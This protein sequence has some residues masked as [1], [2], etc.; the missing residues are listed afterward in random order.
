MKTNYRNKNA[1]FTLV[2][3]L[4]VIAIIGI[5]IG[6]L[7]P[8]VQ[9]VREAARRIQC[10]NNCRQLGLAALNH[11]SSTM[12]FPSGWKIGVDNDPLAEPGWGWGAQLLPYIEQG[13]VGDQIDF[14]VAI[15]D[16]S[17]SEIIRTEMSIF[18]C[19]SDP[20]DQLLNLDSHVEGHDDDDDHD[21]DG[22][23]IANA[24]DDDDDHDHDEELW[25][26]RNNY[27][28]CFGNIEIEDS[29]LFGNGIM[30]ANSEVT[31]GL[32]TDGSSNTIMVGE[33]TN[34]LGTIS[35]VGMVPEVDEPFARVVGITDHT[36]NH[37]EMHFDDFRSHHTGGINATYSD[38]STHFISDNIDFQA[39]QALGSRNGGEVA[40]E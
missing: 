5:L 15:D 37:S 7:L 16:P 34:E 6:M 22:L 21:D 1:A 24:D 38:G 14:T 30:Y 27:S 39:Y 25:V 18:L 36:P 29:P 2:E 33:R 32:I 4:V 3:L 19:P 35:W 8:A 23:A 11:E 9:S 28:G 17:H 12:K 31:F 26:S 20:A 40:A 13:N 10:A